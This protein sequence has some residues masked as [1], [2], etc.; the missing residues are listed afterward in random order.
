[1]PRDVAVLV[2]PHHFGSTLL[3]LL[4]MRR[5][6][7]AAAIQF[8]SHVPLKKK[9]TIVFFRLF[10]TFCLFCLYSTRT[11]VTMAVGD[12]KD[13][14]AHS[15]V[16]L[17]LAKKESA[18]HMVGMEDLYEAMRNRPLIVKAYALDDPSEANTPS[19]KGSSPSKTVH[20]VRHGQGFHNLMA[21][22]AKAQGREWVQVRSSFYSSC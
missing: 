7:S 11:L 12:N 1:M 21:D 3:L 13:L 2:L 8:L 14:A 22:L 19:S 15:A 4:L 18:E 6:L 20:F 5:A 16:T 10:A 9:K 17:E